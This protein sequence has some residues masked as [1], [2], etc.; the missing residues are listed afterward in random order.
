MSGNLLPGSATNWER[1]LADALDTTASLAPSID[2]VRGTK[3]IAPPP[4]FLPFLIYEYGLGELTPYVPN[5]YDLIAEGID[6]QRVRGT[7]AAMALALAWLGYTAEIEEESTQRRFWNLFQ[8]ELDRVRD[9]RQD[10][11]RIAGVAMLSVPKRSVFWRGFHGLDI[12]PLTFSESHYGESHYGEYSGHRLAVGGPLWSFGRRYEFD[13]AASE[14]DLTELGVWLEPVED[15]D[16]GWGDFSWDSTEASWESSAVRARSEAMAS[17]VIGRQAWF[18]FFDAEN[19]IIGYRRARAH[20]FVTSAFAGAYS[21]LGSAYEPKPTVDTKIYLECQTGFG[22]GDGRLAT[23]FGVVFD[24]VPDD[25]ARPG[26]MWLEAGELIDGSEPVLVSDV[27]I[28]FGETIRE[29]V[30]LLMRF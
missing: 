30:K 1:A 9:S 4:S 20:H 19:E 12:R 28:A 11:D 7:P 26:Q 13:I 23:S 24:A 6:W 18:V 16:L 14:A 15:E 10:L 27:D 5:L 17:G 25:P 8:L 29:R 3:I 22:E 2:A 21:V